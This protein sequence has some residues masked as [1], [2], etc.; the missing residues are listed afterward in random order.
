MGIVD[1]VEKPI[2]K[3]LFHVFDT[4]GGGDYIMGRVVR[5]ESSGKMLV[6]N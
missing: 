4:R 2:M 3:G 5:L 1:T 6:E